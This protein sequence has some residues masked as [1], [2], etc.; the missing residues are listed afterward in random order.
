MKKTFLFAIVAML[1]S[2]NLNAQSLKFGVKA[3]VNFSNYSGTGVNTDALTS[4]H[5]G[6]VT[7]IKVF[8]NFAIQPELMY[9]TQGASLNSL[10]NSI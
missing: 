6:L 5:A 8:K 3:G 4:F 1:F 7:E 10:G 9:S 2:F